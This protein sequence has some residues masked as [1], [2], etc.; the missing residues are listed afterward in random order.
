MASESV[1]TPTP[2]ADAPPLGTPAAPAGESGD[3]PASA[4]DF[5][6][7]SLAAHE[8]AHG[9]DDDSDDEHGA[10]PRDER[11]ERGQ[12][13]RRRA[14]SQRADSDDVPTI[15]TLTARLKAAEETH[16]KDIARLPN[17]SDRV[18]TLRRRAELLE[19]LAAPVPSAPAV[20]P[21]QAVLPPAPVAAPQAPSAAAPRATPPQIP[22]FPDFEAFLKLDG[23]ENADYDTYRDARDE[24]RYRSRRAIEQQEAAA[25]K[26]ADTFNANIKA[27]QSRVTEARKKY[28]DWDTHVRADVRI[29]Q[30]VEEALLGSS[31]SADVAYYLGTHP[32]VLAELNTESSEYSPS[33]VSAMRRY[34]DAIVAQQRTSSPSPRGAAGSTGSAPV[35][36]PPPAPR[37]PN[38][39]RTS[40]MTPADEPPGDES[41]LAAHEKAYGRRR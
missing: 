12:F 37:P 22:A 9:R 21:A 8:A 7:G 35:A 26:A 40:A 33:A 17:E 31:D 24:Y 23:N 19:R 34:L 4:S 14:K 39:V 2:V 16:G 41:S 1:E 25:Q 5:E 36:V 32:D 10:E 29:S 20:V 13:Q 18:Y 15:N 11:N 28:P 30:V 27:H 6:D 38:P 3:A